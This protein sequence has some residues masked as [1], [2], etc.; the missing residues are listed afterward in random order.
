MLDRIGPSRA[1]QTAQGMYLG[2]VVSAF[3]DVTRCALGGSYESH[4]VF[5]QAPGLKLI[6]KIQK[7]NE[8]F[9]DTF[10]TRGH[11]RQ[12]SPSSDSKGLLH[13]PA[14]TDLR[15]DLDAYAEL[16]DIIESGDYECPEPD[17]FNPKSVMKHIDMVYQVNRGAGLGTVRIPT[18][19]L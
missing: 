17:A 9:S 7:M 15:L 3:Q 13:N 1:E 8:R 14:G 18:S 4:A 10:W 11:L 16:H 12:L 19:A 2:N 5:E 6:T